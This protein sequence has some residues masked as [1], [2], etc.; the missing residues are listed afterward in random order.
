MITSIIA[1]RIQ[2][3]LGIPWRIKKTLH[4]L[5]RFYYWLGM[6]LDIRTFV[7]KCDTCKVTKATNQILRTPMGTPVLSERF[8]QRV[9]IDL[10]MPTLGQE[11][12]SLLS[13]LVS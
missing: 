5:R 11:K 4:H 7:S 12:L 2:R 10:L 1:S 9:Y 3:T 8:F 13:S 6:L